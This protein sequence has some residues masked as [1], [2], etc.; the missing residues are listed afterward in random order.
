LFT[1]VPPYVE[2]TKVPCQTPVPIVPTDV[3]L[4]NVETAELTSVPDEDGNVIVV[5]AVPAKLT[6]FNI[7]FD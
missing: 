7:K 4:D 5:P 1:P 3:K 6:S 2:P